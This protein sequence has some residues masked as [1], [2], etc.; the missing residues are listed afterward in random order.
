[1]NVL[2]TSAG[3]RGYLV[4][5]FREAVAPD[6]RVIAANCVAN[7]PGMLA[8]DASCVVP[9]GGDPNFV[10]ALLQVCQEHHVGLLFSLH[11]WEAP[12]IAAS[13]PRFEALGVRLGVSSA[14]VLEICLDKLKAHRFCQSH[15]I[16]SPQTFGT[17]GEVLAALTAGEV[18]FPLIVKPRHGQGDMVVH[19]V[20]SA[21]ELAAACLLAEAEVRRFADNGLGSGCEVPFVIQELI[22]GDEYG[23]DV[24][25]DFHGR[26][27]ACLAKRKLREWSGE[28]DAAITVEDPMLG[29]LGERIGTCLRH[30]AMLDADVIV[31]DGQPFLLEMNPRFGGHYPFSHQAG[32]NVPAALVALASGREPDPALLRVMPG[33]ASQKDLVLKTVN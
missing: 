23:L 2:L 8:A 1:V 19:R 32:A 11:D 20:F 6:G 25:N 5:Y 12:F 7:T 3:R 29:E 30:T 17:Q 4:E 9:K 15:G 31:R 27:R 22:V 21:D 18:H 10:D 16:A 26:F 28:T 24:I 14:E 13:A 33:V